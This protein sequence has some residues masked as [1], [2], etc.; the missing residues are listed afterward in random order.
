MPEELAE[1]VAGPGLMRAIN[2]LREEFFGAI[3]KC[4][5]DIIQ[6]IS[7]CNDIDN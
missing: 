4:V 3:R 6:A 7:K 2:I 1:E 5:N